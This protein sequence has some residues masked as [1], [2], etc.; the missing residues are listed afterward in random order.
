MMLA[1]FTLTL[2][3]ALTCTTN[4]GQ[5]I[6]E[7]CQQKLGAS[8]EDVQATRRLEYPLNRLQM[9]LY[10]CI[11]QAAGYSDGR[12]FQRETYLKLAQASADKDRHETLREIAEHCD[13]ISN[14]DDSCQLAAD[15]VGCLRGQILKHTGSNQ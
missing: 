1:T 7:A 12:R 14:K 6:D 2:T 4:A 13:G 3:M 15:I 10:D 11:F 5:T 8:D 9:C